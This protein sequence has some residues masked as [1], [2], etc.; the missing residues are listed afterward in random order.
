MAVAEKTTPETVSRNPQQQLAVSSL[1]GALYL[2]FSIGL[3]LSGLPT[4]WREINVTA[5]FNNNVFLAEALLLVV[6]LP[7]MVGLVL[8]VLYL[9]HPQRGVRAGA[10]L[11]AVLLFLTLLIALLVANL[12]APQ[13]MG[14]AVEVG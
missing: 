8:I 4:L 9:Q 7:V 10:V 13:N 12:L 3:V 5:A 1:L 2:L 6:T 11:G 14:V